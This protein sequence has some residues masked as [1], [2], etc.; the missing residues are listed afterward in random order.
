M[1]DTLNR[2]T[3]ILADSYSYCTSVR[4][5]V[6]QEWKEI[7]VDCYFMAEWDEAAGR[8]LITTWDKQKG[9]GSQR[10]TSVEAF[11]AQH[12]VEEAA[13]ARKEWKA[14]LFH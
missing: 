1:G 8:L 14:G 7:T 11:T 2:L 9:G 4:D 3:L 10:G 6:H 12:A 5:N 13:R